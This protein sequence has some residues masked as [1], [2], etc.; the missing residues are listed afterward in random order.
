MQLVSEKGESFDEPFLT[1]VEVTFRDRAFAAPALVHAVRATFDGEI[2]I[3]GYALEHNEAKLELTLFWRAL[4]YIPQ[5]YKYFVH[6]WQGD[7]VVAQVDSMPVA[8]QYPTSWWAPGEVVSE[9]VL[10]DVGDLESDDFGVTTGFYDPA[11]GRRLSVVLSDGANADVG[12]VT[13]IETP[14]E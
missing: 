12:W 8:W 6:L 4:G 3:L 11:D 14:D 9:Q 2:E 5:D 1:T 13:L 7:T 10:F